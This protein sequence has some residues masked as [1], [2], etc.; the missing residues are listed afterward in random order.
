MTPKPKTPSSTELLD[1]I[2]GSIRSGQL[3][4]TQI[5]SIFDQEI[6]IESTEGK[7]KTKTRICSQIDHCGMVQ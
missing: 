2:G 4:A 5:S 6:V 3:S 7:R 1:D